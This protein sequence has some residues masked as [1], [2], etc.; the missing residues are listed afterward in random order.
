[1]RLSL[2]RQDEP[3]TK[4]A[5]D[6]TFLRMTRRPEGP[7]RPLPADASVQRVEGCTVAF[8]R[9]LY[10]TVGHDYVWWLRRTLPDRE[11]A[12]IL[13]DPD[14]SIHVLYRG[15]QPAGFFELERRPG[16][17]MNLSY[18]G[19]MPQAV[20]QRLG[21]AFLRAAVETAWAAASVAVTVNTC[22]ADHARA[23]PNYIAAGF[24]PMQTIREVWRVPQRLGLPIPERLL[25]R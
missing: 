12:E 10:A 8:Y 9:Y 1:M 24:V 14:V 13:A 22:T 5:V 16:G 20:G 17:V 7:A 15:G 23:L 18:F 21:V 2:V 11:L 6:V 4:I 3:A 25:V 19:L